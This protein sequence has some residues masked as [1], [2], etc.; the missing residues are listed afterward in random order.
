MED[1]MLKWISMIAT[2]ATALATGSANA[3]EREAILKR[4][5]VPG[6]GFDIVVAMAKSGSRAEYYRSQPDPNVVYLGDGLVIGYTPEVAEMVDIEMLMHPVHATV[7][8][9]G[10]V[11]TYFVRKR[12]QSTAAVQ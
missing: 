1:A 5:A 9:S 10:T 6:A 8:A 11:L 12:T 7:G 2:L 4:I 3:Q